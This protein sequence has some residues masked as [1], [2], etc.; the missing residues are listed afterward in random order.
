M[1]RKIKIQFLILLGVCLLAIFPAQAQVD[2]RRDAV[3]E[4]VEKVKSSVVNINTVQRIRVRDQFETPFGLYYGPEH[5]AD[6]ASLGSG[7]IVDEDGYILSNNHVVQ[8]AAEIQVLIGTNN[9]RAELVAA[10]PTVDVALLKI[11]KH[12]KNE[13]FHAIKFARD[14]DVLLGERVVALG[15]PF[16][17]GFSVSSGILSSTTRRPETDQGVLDYKDWLQTDAAINPGNSGGPLVDMRGELI[18]LNVAV[19][20]EQNA[21]GIGFA[22]PIKRVAEALSEILTSEESNQPL[23]FGA[24]ITSSAGALRIINVESGSPIEKAGL[25]KGDVILQ[26]G[27]KKPRNFIEFIV[28]FLRLSEQQKTA[29]EK[30]ISL[31]VLRGTERIT[32]VIHLVAQKNVFN[33]DLIRKKIGAIFHEITPDLQQ[34][35]GLPPGQGFIVA[36]VDP[37]SP[38]EKAGLERGF[39]IHTIDGEAPSNIGEAAKIFYKKKPN[40]DVKLAVTVIRGQSGN[41]QIRQGVIIMKVR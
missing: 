28:E 24:K 34:S 27:E 30:N 37:N 22:I 13:K 16:G 18:G 20:R 2:I 3:V 11:V 4:A 5:E 9:Y 7:V 38:A 25:R 33:A 23:W 10:S 8:R 21:Q 1:Q 36:G 40:S 29:G 26:I 19:Y 6:R 17:L 14:D 15:N 12:Q 35:L 41:F 32:S 39:L 31:T